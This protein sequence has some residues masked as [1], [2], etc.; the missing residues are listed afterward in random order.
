M[1]GRKKKTGRTPVILINGTWHRS[2]PGNARS[3]NS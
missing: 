2:R 1:E 3:T